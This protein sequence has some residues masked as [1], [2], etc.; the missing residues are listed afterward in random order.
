MSDL[1]GARPRV[2]LLSN[3]LGIGGTEKGLVSFAT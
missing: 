1:H 2:A 3:T